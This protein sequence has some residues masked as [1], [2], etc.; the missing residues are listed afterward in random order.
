MNPAKWHACAAF[1]AS[2]L[3]H[4]SA[5]AP[6]GA[7]TPSRDQPERTLTRALR[8]FDVDCVEFF[9]SLRKFMSAGAAALA[10]RLDDAKKSS[11]DAPA[12]SGE[13]P[14]KKRRSAGKETGEEE[15]AREDEDS[16]ARKEK[17]GS[18][19]SLAGLEAL[20]A[21]LSVPELRTSFAFT[22]VAAQKYKLFADVHLDGRRGRRA[23]RMAAVPRR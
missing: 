4:A 22:R 13:T 10:K 2:G 1:V 6:E 20:E 3:E 8:V 11:G 19:A 9:R 16:D 7:R 15:A 18:T 21:A 12:G 5:S 23:L 14:E 17:G